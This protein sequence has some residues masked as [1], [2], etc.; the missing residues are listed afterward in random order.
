[1]KSAEVSTISKCS[2]ILF[3]SS[4][5]EMD[6]RLVNAFNEIFSLHKLYK[7]QVY[8]PRPTTHSV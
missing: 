7:N 8:S 2:H 6:G 4:Q 5:E 3:P 1:M